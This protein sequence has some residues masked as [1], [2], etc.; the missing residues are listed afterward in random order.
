MLKTIFISSSVKILIY[1]ILRETRYL[2]TKIRIYI[3]KK[4]LRIV[5][6]TCACISSF[7]SSRLYIQLFN[8]NSQ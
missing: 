3:Y 7:L 1:Y 2:L 8:L 5:F 4:C 6:T